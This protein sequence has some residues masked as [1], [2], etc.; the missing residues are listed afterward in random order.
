[1]LKSRIFA[2]SGVLVTVFIFLASLQDGN[3]SANMSNG[4]LQFLMTL[5]ADTGIVISHFILRK[6]AH[7][8][9]FFM[10]SVF[11]SLS[12]L[13]SEKG[14]KKRLVTIAFGGLMTACC[15]EFLQY[16]SFGRSAQVSDI[17]IDFTGTLSALI[18]IYLISILVKRRRYNV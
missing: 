9:E 2:I 6:A 5:L 18:V 12:A 1:M 11:F 14:L 15:D 3:A 16:F 8:T 4:L 10:Q 7:F 17:F 13:Y